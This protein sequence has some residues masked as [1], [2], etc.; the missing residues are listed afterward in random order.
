ML[1]S[2]R[3]GR[4]PKA[5]IMQSRN[6]LGG[7]SGVVPLS[8]WINRALDI[9]AS[10]G[11]AL[12]VSSDAY[13][14]PALRIAS[15]LAKQI[16]KAEEESLP[17]LSTRWFESDDNL[18]INLPVPDSNWSSKVVVS[19]EDVGHNTL[20]ETDV[21]VGG[22]VDRDSNTNPSYLTVAS[23]K[24]LSTKAG[25][26]NCSNTPQE[27]LRRIH[28]L[29][30]VFYEI[31]SG[32]DRPL[33]HN[34]EMSPQFNDIILNPLPIGQVN[35]HEMN[36]AEVRK[37]IDDLE[38]NEGLQMPPKKALQSKN[39]AISSEQLK[40]KKIPCP[41]CD[42]VANML[43]CANGGLS[44]SEA[45]RSMSDVLVDLQL[46]LDKPEIYLRGIDLDKVSSN[47]LHFS[48]SMFGRER[49]L[50]VVTTAHKRSLL[51]SS[52]KELVVITGPAGSGKSYLSQRFGDYVTASGGLFLSAKFDQL[53]QSRPLSA[54]ASAFNGYCEMLS[55][56]GGGDNGAASLASEM[57]F[58][59][60]DDDIFHLTKIIPSLI[61]ILYQGTC[62]SFSEGNECQ[63]V[64]A[65]QRL[66]F[67]MCQFVE[68]IT[69]STSVPIT[70]QID[71]LHNADDASV[72]VINQLIFTS[73]STQ[74]IFFLISSRDDEKMRKML[75]NLD[76]FEVPYVQIKVDNLD[77]LEINKTMSELLHLSPRLTRPLSSIAHRKT[78]GNALFFSRWMMSLVE[79]GL[80]Q[81]SLSR[82]RWVWDEDEIRRVKL[83]DDVAMLFRDSIHK[84]PGDVQ[85]ALSVM[86][87][88]G[89]SLDD[90]LADSL[91]QA[92][93]IR[94]IAPLNAAVSGGLL[95]KINGQYRFCHDCVQEAAYNV[96]LP[97][98]KCLHHFQH[99]LSL[100]KLYLVEVS[101]GQGNDEILFSAVNQ[102]NLGGP[103]ALEA[104]EE[105]FTVS[106]LNLKAGKKA[107]EMSDFKAAYSFFDNG[108][109][110]LRKRHWQQ[111]YELSMELF[112]LAS[113]CAL[114]TGDFV[115][116]KLLSE[117]V[118]RNATVFEQKIPVMYYCMCARTFSG[119]F[120]EGAKQ[121]ESTLSQL[122][123]ALPEQSS[124]SEI[125][126][127]VEEMLEKLASY[128]ISELKDLKRMDDSVKKITML[129]L[130]QLHFCYFIISPEK[131]PIVTTKM[132]QLTL[133][134]GMCETSPL[135]FAIFGSMLGKL[136]NIEKGYQYTKLAKQLVEEN[137][138]YE[139]SGV[140]ISTAAQLL[141]YVEPVQ[142]VVPLFIEARERSM[143]AGDAAN[144]CLSILQYCNEGYISGIDL[145]KL[146]EKCFQARQ[147]MKQLGHFTA[148][149]HLVILERHL[150]SL[151]GA[152]WEGDHH[153]PEDEEEVK[154]ANPHTIF[155][156]IIYKL[157]NNFMFR[158]YSATK[159]VLQQFLAH[160]RVDWTLMFGQSDVTFTFG[161][162]V[163]W[164][165]RVSKE[166]NLK[167]AGIKAKEA[168]Q[169]WTTSSKWNFEHK[170]LL[171][172]AE[173][174]FCDG[175]F[176]QAKPLY[177]KAIKSAKEH[178]FVNGEAIACELAGYFYLEMGDKNTAKDYFIKA[179]ERYLT[180][181]ALGKAATLNQEIKKLSTEDK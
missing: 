28:S 103:A 29:G 176:D 26:V 132:I 131:Q 116:L 64:D 168:M 25:A 27:K 177:A 35:T 50:S 92:L 143:S 22:D 20:S 91:E 11:G 37:I 39:S 139:S 161:L 60:R 172:D 2:G 82:R 156:S 179:H 117:Q 111:H 65:Q 90:V 141:C 96:I 135:A 109:S 127:S 41:L 58:R 63:V 178:R 80:L 57:R 144:A 33:L 104:I 133:S 43:D 145:S 129:F 3:Y 136:G 101:M 126:N 81:P 14:I 34:C 169:G 7:A 73:K 102:L 21:H 40:M 162:V 51:S 151:M 152:A 45:Y 77:E 68:A 114:A 99:G 112:C 130:R 79:G 105:A 17:P 166:P 88:F 8:N 154:E 128:S 83:P 140:V 97:Q 36:L 158:R 42:L 93:H 18:Q 108:I 163:F 106:T 1:S 134:H 69:M 24:L 31:F 59:L 16:C 155:F 84:L 115:G 52:E 181:G 170:L 107:M 4:G 175:N 153:V 118:L 86:A 53:K 122:G 124:S 62:V 138:F 160:N 174:N 49:K 71:D 149:S 9:A 61:N 167:H 74:K 123:E 148:L 121:I 13:I 23:A 171:L 100:A 157:T 119:E 125:L 110:F 12:T 46:M 10:E 19:L 150:Q 55:R 47:E 95:D 15:S 32:G 44:D 66:Q 48:D 89:A 142:A 38:D 98:E 165:T 56:G 159:S 180:W 72:G 87:C 5:P 70:F 146:K 147:L 76:H 113:K 137:T 54:L 173:E 78:R 75:T 67:L 6:Q 30:L 94:L 120:F 164:I 85:K